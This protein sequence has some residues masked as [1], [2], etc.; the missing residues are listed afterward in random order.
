MTKT[1]EIDLM[2]LDKDLRRYLN[3]VVRKN[4]GGYCTKLIQD[5]SIE[6][7][8]EVKHTPYGFATHS[9]KFFPHVTT[10]KYPWSGCYSAAENIV[11]F[12]N[13]VRLDRLA[14]A[15]NARRNH[16]AS[17]LSKIA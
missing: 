12:R 17:K 8:I 6:H 11:R 16:S 15:Y 2:G 4:R 10:T 3:S 13:W 9:G 5:A 14:R 1:K 7:D